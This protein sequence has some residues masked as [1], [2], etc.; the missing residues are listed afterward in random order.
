MA[1][2]KTPRWQR[3]GGALLAVHLF[4]KGQ[5]KKD[6]LECDIL[7]YDLWVGWKDAYVGHVLGQRPI[8]GPFISVDQPDGNRLAPRGIQCNQQCFFRSQ[9]RNS[10][11]SERD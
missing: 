2:E 11:Y 10:I 7:L 6:D 5:G 1:V 8:I 4:L 9:R 3:L